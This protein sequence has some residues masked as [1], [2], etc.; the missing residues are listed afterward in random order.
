MMPIQSCNLHWSCS[1]T[2]VLIVHRAIR[3][4]PATQRPSGDQEQ[5]MRTDHPPLYDNTLTGVLARL[6]HGI[7][8]DAN[9]RAQLDR[10]KRANASDSSLA[11]SLGTSFGKA[12]RK[13]RSWLSRVD[14]WF[15]KQEMKRREVF[16]AQ[17]ADIFDLERRMRMLERGGN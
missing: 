15:W 8:L 5:P 11:N 7:L 2:I 6:T 12:F 16:L 17:S 14:T 13:S 3:A 4:L 10:A 9:Q 1:D